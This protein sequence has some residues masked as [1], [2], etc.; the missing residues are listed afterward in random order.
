VTF[1]K[2]AKRLCGAASSA[3]PVLSLPRL[4]R[5]GIAV[6]N[7][8]DTRKSTAMRLHIKKM[9]ADGWSIT[10]RDPVRLERGPRVQVVRG[11]VL[12]GG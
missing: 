9:Q 3:S 8:V 2:R 10:G 12:I 5:G 7:F 1:Q 4:R 11:E 6:D